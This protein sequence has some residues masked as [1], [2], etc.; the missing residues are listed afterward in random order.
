[1]ILDHSRGAPAVA[2]ASMSQRLGLL[3]CVTTERRALVRGID[4]I[5]AAQCPYTGR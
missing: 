5:A 2:L 3:R 1:M 4:R